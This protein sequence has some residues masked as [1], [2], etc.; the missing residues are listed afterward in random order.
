MATKSQKAAPVAATAVVP[1]M[2]DMMAI[3]QQV[4]Q[5]QQQQL[6]AAQ[7]AP[8]AVAAPAKGE[9]PKA[10]FNGAKLAGELKGKPGVV[11]ERTQKGRVKMTAFCADGSIVSVIL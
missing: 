6:A 5:Q 11:E 10:G 2:A 9:K 8:K 7:A 3:M 4:M 1:N